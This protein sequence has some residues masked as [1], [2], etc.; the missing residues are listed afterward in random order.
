VLWPRVSAA[1]PV[2]ICS[3]KEAEFAQREAG[4][5][6]GGSP[7][8]GG[9]TIEAQ[10]PSVQHRPKVR[11]KRTF[12]R[13]KCPFGRCVFLAGGRSTGQQYA[14]VL[15]AAPAKSTKQTRKPAKSTILPN[16]FW[17][18]FALR[19]LENGCGDSLSESPRRNGSL[20]PFSSGALRSSVAQPVLAR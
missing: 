11:S 1:V 9:P 2:T 7:G 20:S 5:V 17:A 8:D 16:F 10:W 13:S 6:V 14:N 15:L 12:G 4:R 18:P 19:E 3:L